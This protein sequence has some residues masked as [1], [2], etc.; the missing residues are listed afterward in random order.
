M[1]DAGHIREALANLVVNAQKYGARGGEIRVEL[2]DDGTSAE[3]AVGNA[4][5][6][7]PR[8]TL[9][10]MFEPLRRGGVSGGESELFSLG[11]GL[12]IVSQIA[13]A[14]DGTIRAE[15]GGGKTTFELRLPGT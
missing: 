1:F 9:D 13:Q 2:R 15:S 6:P 4:G 7:I 12:F 3:L 8:E 14:H 5:E 11:L 10:L